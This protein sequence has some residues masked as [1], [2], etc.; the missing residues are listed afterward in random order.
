MSS[1]D[2]SSTA[3]DAVDRWT[4]TRDIGVL[5]VKLIV[6]G[7]RDFILVPVSIVVGIYSLMQKGRPGDNE[8]YNLLRVGRRSERW[9]NLFGAADRV[10]APETERVNFP[11]D[12]IDSL[13]KKLEDF[14]VDEYQSGGVTKQA[15]DHLDQMLSSIGRRRKR[16][17]SEP[18][19][20]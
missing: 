19:A 11:Q 13:V 15:K 6:D 5:Q 16:G 7:L 4:L 14:V 17:T 1:D 18:P 12:D 2:L 3:D 9:I 8:F 20:Q 10:R